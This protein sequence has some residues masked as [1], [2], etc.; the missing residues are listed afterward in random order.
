MNGFLRLDIFFS[1]V[2]LLLQTIILLF[3]AILSNHLYGQETP[4]KVHHFIEDQDSIGLE[5]TYVNVHDIYTIKDGID[6][7]ETPLFLSTVYQSGKGNYINT[8]NYGSAS[9]SLRW[10]IAGNTGFNSGYR[11]YL[12]YQINKESFRFYI[13]NRPVSNLYFSQLGSQDNITV[14]A[15]F[16]RNFTNG[17]SVSLNYKRIS[18]QGFYNHQATKSTA[19]GMGLRYESPSKKYNAIL[20]FI[21]NAHEERFNGG[22]L[23]DS[24]LSERFRKAIPT[25]LN[26]ASGRQQKQS[27]SFV[28]YYQ[29]NDVS[30]SNWNLYLSNELSYQPEYYKFVD[31]GLDSQSL[32][33]YSLPEHIAIPAGLRRYTDIKTYTE[34]FNIHGLNA[35]GIQ[36][37]VGLKYDY[38]VVDDLP[39][40]FKR[41][42]LTIIGEGRIPFLKVLHINVKGKLGLLKNIGTF[43]LSGDIGLN[44]GKIGTLN[45]GL[46]LFRL[47]PAYNETILNVNG[48]SV[49]DTSYTNAFGT[50]MHSALHIPKLRLSISLS[51]SIINNP[52]YWDIN[53]KPAQY[54]NIITLS[55]FDLHHKLVYKH[56]GLENDVYFQLQSSN[57]FPL[58]KLYTAHKLYYKGKWFNQV[59]EMN[60]GLDGRLLPSYNGPSYQPLY[61]SYSQSN[62][63]LPFAPEVNFFVH[64]KVSTFRAL[65]SLENFSRY[66][67]KTNLYNISGYPVFDPTFRFGLQWLLKD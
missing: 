17:F 43:D 22:I 66:W 49:L 41:S 63:T 32:A 16:S 12:P 55:Q 21:Q 10:D 67:V 6:S 5:Y 18:Q 54:Q 45:G 42:D 61:D 46:R 8:G 23:S 64:A 1:T 50:K 33:Y 7:L 35:N 52:M 56:F 58:P 44:I 3:S 20:L 15:D 40:S 57:I 38:I 26:E 60:I 24:L 65:F 59:M 13:Q 62:S 29:L 36:G 53:G 27:L 9:M 37:K 30:S 34:V 31:Q 2:R 47:E 4:E 25:L 39:T 19:F 14:G 28:Q 51:Q 48:I 11:Q